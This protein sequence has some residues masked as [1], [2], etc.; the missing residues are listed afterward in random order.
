M[1]KESNPV[2]SI[3][4]VLKKQSKSLE[5]KIQK[6]PLSEDTYNDAKSFL[7]KFQVLR[8]ELK[9][10]NATTDKKVIEDINNFEQSVNKYMSVY[11][12]LTSKEKKELTKQYKNQK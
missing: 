2:N 12:K 8:D 10:N 7:H 9:Q 11:E 1:K 4:K 5:K 3:I 6:N